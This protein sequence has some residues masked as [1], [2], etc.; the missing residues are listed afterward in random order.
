MLPRELTGK[1]P[2]FLTTESIHLKKKSSNV[3]QE[4]NFKINSIK[5]IKKVKRRA[6]IF[7]NNNNNEESFSNNNIFKSKNNDIQR[8]DLKSDLNLAPENVELYKRKSVKSFNKIKIERDYSGN[9]NKNVNENNVDNKD[10]MNIR[11]FSFQNKNSDINEKDNN[12]NNSEN[13]HEKKKAE[14]LKNNL[15]GKFFF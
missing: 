12:S 7:S 3:D 6:T 8:E 13:I 15:I 11:V 9:S 4:L 1:I 14:F 5:D 2:N 10:R